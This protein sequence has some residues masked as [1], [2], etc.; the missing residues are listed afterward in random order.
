MFQIFRDYFWPSPPM[1]ISEQS[2]AAMDADIRDKG[3]WDCTLSDAH[4]SKVGVW[5]RHSDN[6][7]RSANREWF[8]QHGGTFVR[9]WGALSL[10]AWAAGW[11]AIGN[12]WLEVLFTLVGFISGYGAIFWLWL[13]KQK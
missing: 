9:R 5:V 4:R 2:K 13:L 8:K 11:S 12:A 10:L 6:Q 1:S 7:A 3:M